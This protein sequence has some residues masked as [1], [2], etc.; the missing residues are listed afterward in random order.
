M[1]R[2]SKNNTNL[3]CIEAGFE[4]KQQ[5]N[6]AIG[7]SK[8]ITKALIQHMDSVIEEFKKQKRLREI[9]VCNSPIKP[10]PCT[11]LDNYSSQTT[12]DK[13]FPHWLLNHQDYK[14]QKEI[15]DSLNEEQKTEVMIALNRTTERFRSYR[16]S[17]G[18]KRL[19]KD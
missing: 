7:K 15:Y 5:F 1:V 19:R 9:A 18:Y 17:D 6:E 8:S 10:Q 2:P 4:R 13:Y 16:H 3:L 14:F 12:L 11:S